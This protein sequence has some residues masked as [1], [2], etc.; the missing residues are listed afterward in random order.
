MEK[1]AGTY[2][3]TF[4]LRQISHRLSI[5]ER[6]VVFDI[7]VAGHKNRYDL[8]AAVVMEDHVHVLLQAAVSLTRTFPLPKIMHRIK[9][10]SALQVNKL[11]RRKGALWQ[12]R[13]HNRL[14]A[15]A[16]E[17]SQKLNYIVDNPRRAGLAADPNE[18]PCL[19]YKGKDEM[20]EQ[21]G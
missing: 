2:F 3:V 9:G 18:Y 14:I 19:W 11:R 6:K 12:A 7:V 20:M 4:R 1:P 13:Y 21:P 16:H 5:P 17:Y 15:S 10:F 8:H